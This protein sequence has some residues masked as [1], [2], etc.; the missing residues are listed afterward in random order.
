MANDVSWESGYLALA[1]DPHAI[2]VLEN[3]YAPALQQKRFSPEE[4]GYLRDGG[5]TKSGIAIGPQQ[6][7]MVSAAFACRRVIAEDVAKMPRAVKRVSSKNGR[8][9]LTVIDDHPL[10]EVLTRRPNDW[11]TAMQFVE[12]MVGI[13]TMHEAAY[14]YVVRD[15]AGQVIELLPLLPGTVSVEQDQRW[16]VTY[17]VTGYGASWEAVP[18][19]LFCLM[20]PPRDDA[21][22]GVSISRHAREALGL[23]AAIEASQARF[24]ANDMRPSGTIT[25]KNAVTPEIKERMRISWQKAYGPGGTGG[26][27]ILDDDFKYEGMEISAADNQVIDNRKFQIEEVCRF[28]RVIPTVIGHNSGSQAYGSVE[29]MFTAHVSHTLQPWVVRFEQAATRWLLDQHRE[30]DLIVDIDMNALSR[31]TLTDRFNVYDKGVKFCF[32]PNDIREMEGLNPLDGPEFERPQL[33]AN[34]TGLKPT[35]GGAET[36]PAKP[37]EPAAEPSPAKPAATSSFLDIE[38]LP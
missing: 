1:R 19:E 16:D 17:R 21:L 33:L 34:N 13:A 2:T 30:R 29:Q 25:T 36:A 31:G 20:G 8:R 9:V 27:A 28:F 18:G 6:A 38:P 3:A 26:V 7:L 22:S 32:S 35:T 5:I 37:A 11:M 12:W 23:A 24:H 4:E 10:H 14:A 15:H